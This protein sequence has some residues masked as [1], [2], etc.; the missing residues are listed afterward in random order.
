[1]DLS[2]LT[3]KTMYGKPI[4]FETKIAAVKLGE[5][6][7]E[8][9]QPVKDAPLFEEFLENVGEGINHIAFVV[10]DLEKETAKL[11]DKGVKVIL[12]TRLTSGGGGV[13]LD[14]REVGGVIIELVQW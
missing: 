7:L 13:Y 5:V 11:V 9:I 1:M 3:G 4:D 14:T 2:G 12:T 6:G 10:D 8:L